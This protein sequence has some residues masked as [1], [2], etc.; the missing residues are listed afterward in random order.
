MANPKNSAKSSADSATTTRETLTSLAIAFT[1]A[2]L[3]RGFVL[4]AFLIPTGSMAPTLLGQHMR[5][6]GE[7]T[8]AD[9]TVGPWY[10]ADQARQIPLS[11]QQPRPGRDPQITLR[12]PLTGPPPARIPLDDFRPGLDVRP[13]GPVPRLAGDRIFVLKYLPGIFGPERFDV[14]VFKN[15][16]QPWENYIKRLVGLPGEQVAIIDG[17][18]FSRPASAVRPE[19]EGDNSWSGDGWSIRR[20]PDEIQRRSWWTIAD[21]FH[22]PLAPIAGL[23][24]PWIE[25]AGWDR[26]GPGAMT[27]ATGAGGSLR[28]DTRQW[29]ITDFLAYNETPVFISSESR[30]LREGMPTSDLRIAM[31]VDIGDDQQVIRP[32][33]RARQHEF[34]AVIRVDSVD[35]VMTPLDGEGAPMTASAETLATAPIRSKLRPGRASTIE[36]WHV[37][38]ALAVWIDGKRIIRAEYDWSPARRVLMTT[39]STIDNL[40]AQPDAE[41]VFADVRTWAARGASEPRVEFDRG[42]AT[43][44]RL[45]LCRDLHYQPAIY[46]GAMRGE[47]ALATHPWSSPVLGPDQFFACGDNS[48]ASLDSRLW[49]DADPWVRHAMPHADIGVVPREMVIGR[50]FFVY[51]PAL[52]SRGGIPTPDV[53]RMR[54]IR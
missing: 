38:Q 7:A 3:F 5:F 9:W 47:P 13:G 27:L 28:W 49:E 12:D 54:F 43:V 32:T 29:P 18:I 10:Y 34:S 30:D 53:G 4:E 40:L 16:T 42:G 37:D 48:A 35:L 44:H 6:R 41:R 17:D 39:G 52:R 14:F 45:A 26:K 22:T 33:I 20:K 21:T 1:M 46:Q 24:S 50:A 8:G 11:P 2:F 36:F 31:S 25:S 15:P 23:V 51:F 19:A